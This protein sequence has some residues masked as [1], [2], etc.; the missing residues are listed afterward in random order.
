MSMLAH[1]WKHILKKQTWRESRFLVILLLMC[2][3]TKRRLIVLMNAPFG[4]IAL[5]TSLQRLSIVKWHLATEAVVQLGTIAGITGVLPLDFFFLVCIRRS[6]EVL[7]FQW[8][9]SSAR[10]SRWITVLPTLSWRPSAPSCAR[11]LQLGIC[12]EEV[13]ARLRPPRHSRCLAKGA[14]QS[15]PPSHWHHCLSPARHRTCFR[16]VCSSL[17]SVAGPW[18]WRLVYR[19]RAVPVSSALARR[20]CLA[21]ASMQLPWGI[22]ATPEAGSSCTKPRVWQPVHQ[23]S[24]LSTPA[25]VQLGGKSHSSLRRISNAPC[26]RVCHSV[27]DFGV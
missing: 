24:L 17:L 25:F 10:P 20:R 19:H 16:F 11:V 22:V 2:H 1:S 6:L 21:P 12:R 18:W 23:C 26:L 14:V 9:L 3:V 5:G 8:T 27:R 4:T 13:H 15:P 7:P